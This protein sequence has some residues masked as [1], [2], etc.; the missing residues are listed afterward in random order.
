MAD[1]IRVMGI[2]WQT[3]SGWGWGW[4][5]EMKD[6]VRV[7]SERKMADLARVKGVR[8]DFVRMKGSRDRPCQG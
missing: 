8:G 5:G 3:L 1:I 2:R 6:L 7:T 4:G